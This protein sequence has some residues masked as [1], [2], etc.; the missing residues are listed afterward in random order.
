M[1]PWGRYYLANVS[2]NTG[3]WQPFNSWRMNYMLGHIIK[4]WGYRR[5]AG[6]L[7][8]IA[9]ELRGSP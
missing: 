8:T 2:Y 5:V 4:T 9:K 1:S 6:H 3:W 7:D